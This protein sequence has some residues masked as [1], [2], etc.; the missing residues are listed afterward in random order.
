MRVKFSVVVSFDKGLV[1]PF[2]RKV[3]SFETRMT[4]DS[5]EAFALAKEFC[6]VWPTASVTVFTET[7]EVKIVRE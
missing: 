6:R 5:N 7:I 3:A 1:L 2:G 4:D